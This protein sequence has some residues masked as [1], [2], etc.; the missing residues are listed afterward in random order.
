MKTVFWL[1]LLAVFS[2]GLFVYGRQAASEREAAQIE[3]AEAMIE[4]ERLEA[5]A[6]TLADVIRQLRAGR[7]D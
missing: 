3:L 1:I 7:V 5:R 6:A 2:L 4:I